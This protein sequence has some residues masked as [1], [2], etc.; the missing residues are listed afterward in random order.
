[1]RLI[2]LLPLLFLLPLTNI[3]AI[4]PCNTYKC[5]TMAVRAILDS[6]GLFGES[7]LN[8][9]KGTDSSGRVDS[10][11]FNYTGLAT[12][13]PD[14]GKLTNIAYLSLT[15]NQFIS[16]PPELGQLTKL[17][18]LILQ[19]NPLSNLPPEIGQLTNLKEILDA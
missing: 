3:S 5:D 10:V 6:N 13:P 8:Y 17:K 2:S 19:E 12:F 14:I 4:E 9:I 7:V 18:I 16:L 11:T 1:M 15:G